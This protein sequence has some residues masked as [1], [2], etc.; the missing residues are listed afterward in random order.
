MDVGLVLDEPVL[1]LIDDG[2]GLDLTV[3][4]ITNW[5]GGVQSRQPEG[6]DDVRWLAEAELRDLNLADESYLTVLGQVLG[7]PDPSAGV[8]GHR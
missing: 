1:H 2:T 5:K 4:H 7:R 3:W 8:A 6:H